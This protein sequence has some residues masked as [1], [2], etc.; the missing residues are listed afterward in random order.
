[1]T[2][3]LAVALA[4]GLILLLI[5]IAALHA[6]WGLGGRWPGRDEPT[7][8]GLVIGS[9]RGGRMPGPLACFAVAA[10]LLAG[11]GLVGLISFGSAGGVIY[12]LAKVGYITCALVFT[13]R[14]AVGYV[15]AIWRRSAGTPFVELNTRYYSPLCLL[16]G[17]GMFAN[18]L[19]R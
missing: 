3:A 18:L 14:G 7:L 8:A 5:G 2:H 11:A 4:I 17:A 1:M 13:V 9:T 6:Y 16:I 10:A 19:G 12:G 15:P